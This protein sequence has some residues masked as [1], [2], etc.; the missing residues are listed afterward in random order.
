MCPTSTIDLDVSCFTTLDACAAAG[1][2]PTT[3]QNWLTREPAIILLPKNERPP[4]GLDHRPLLTLRRIFQIGLTAELMRRGTTAQRAGNLAAMFTDQGSERPAE[5]RRDRDHAH[6]RPGHLFPSGGTILVA[7][8]DGRFDPIIAAVVNAPLAEVVRRYKTGALIV[9]VEEVVNG[10]L[11]SLPPM[12]QHTLPVME[13]TTLPF[14]PH[15]PI[16]RALRR[17]QRMV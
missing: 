16:R 17:P 7:N 12:D 15:V 1:I 14:L 3:L 2:K 4:S 13:P 10:I 8:K 5:W 6:R 11:A 9:D